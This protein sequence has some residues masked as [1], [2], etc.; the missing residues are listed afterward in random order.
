M[1]FSP[2]NFHVMNKI[3][4]ASSSVEPQISWEQILSSVEDGVITLDS[5]GSVTFFNEAAELLTE[6]A[7][8]HA[9]S[10]SFARIFRKEPWLVQL[11]RKSFPPLHESSR[12]EGDLVSRWG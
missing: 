10:L 1:L 11:I 7:A 5:S 4:P 8:S 2:C 6:L 9:L 3:Q 12:G